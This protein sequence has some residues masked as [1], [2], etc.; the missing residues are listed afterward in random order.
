MILKNIVRDSKKRHK[1][2]KRSNRSNQDNH[3]IYC[4]EKLNKRNRDMIERESSIKPYSNYRSGKKNSFGRYGLIKELDYYQ[5]TSVRRSFE[6][7]LSEVKGIPHG[8]NLCKNE[9][10]NYFKDY[11][12]DFNTATLPHKKFYDY[13]KWE[14][15][16]YERKKQKAIEKNG[17][18]SNE[19]LY[20][21]E[22]RNK[23]EE[24][25]KKKM[26][27][28]RGAMNNEKIEEMKKQAA[29]KVEMMN[30]YKVGDEERRKKLQKRLEPEEKRWR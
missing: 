15:K 22:M 14:L 23:D 19:F 30:A 21:E 12:E 11:A 7:W 9:N 5:N 20:R 17:V 1:I 29:L 18:V 16:E 6:M 27:I 10:I 28:I 4:E 26:N 8:T 13:N 3:N 25:K 2:S 24:N